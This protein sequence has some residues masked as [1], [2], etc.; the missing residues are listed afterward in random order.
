MMPIIVISLARGPED[1]NITVVETVFRRSFAA[2]LIWIATHIQ[3]AYDC[4]VINYSREEARRFLF[5]G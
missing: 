2:I 4:V 3:Y 1:Q 5:F